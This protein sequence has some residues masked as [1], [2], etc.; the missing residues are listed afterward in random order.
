MFTAIAL[1]ALSP[2]FAQ[3]VIDA[4]VDHLFVPSGFDN[5]DNVEVVVTGYFPN[6]CY[7]RNDVKVDVRGDVVDIKVTA[8]VSD[9]KSAACAAMIVPFKETV[10]VGNLQAGDYKVNVNRSTRFEINEE[11]AV[12]EAASQNQDDHL[13][14][15][16]DYIELGFMGGESGSAQLVG[17]KLSDCLEL[18][19]VEYVPNKKDTVTILPIMKRVREFCPMKMTPLI[20]PVAFNPESFS[21]DK[22]LLMSRTV[23]GRSVNT[24][25]EKK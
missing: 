11:M 8:L 10:N 2:V 17:W 16:V 22:I 5:N 13:Y 20:I 23:D 4:P 18:E 7:K 15:M 3:Q 19:R 24:I 25:V 6:P 9:D 12:V 21:N 1:L 14:A